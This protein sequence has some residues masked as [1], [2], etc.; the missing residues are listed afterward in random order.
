MLRGSQSG[1]PNI[2]NTV[3]DTCTSSHAPTRYNPAMRMTLRRFSSLRNPFTVLVLW[4]CRYW[5][6]IEPDWSSSSDRET[7]RQIFGFAAELHLD[8]I[9]WQ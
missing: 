4:S 5:Q 2:G 1:A 3:P 6:I 9:V 8:L 7:E